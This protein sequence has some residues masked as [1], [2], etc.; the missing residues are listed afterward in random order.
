MVDFKTPLP[1][2]RKAFARIAPTLGLSDAGK[3]ELRKAFQAADRSGDTRRTYH[4]GREALGR[5]AWYWP[6]FDDCAA[7]MEAAGVWPF[8][9]Q[10]VGIAVDTGWHDIP[11]SVKCELVTA[12]LASAVYAERELA[13][14]KELQGPFAVGNPRLDLRIDD[15][16]CAASRWAFDKHARAV[17]GGDLSALP[18]YFPGCAVSV[19]ID[20]G[21]KR[22]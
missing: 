18:P 16:R 2:H 12:T 22:R 15:D 6:W 7:D 10:E 13:S 3:D 11:H 9:W 5:F 4:D 8:R 17:A 20:L 21:L 1:I 19:R 14:L